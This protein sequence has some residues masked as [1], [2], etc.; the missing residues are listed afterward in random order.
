MQKHMQ[1]QMLKLIS[2]IRNETG[3][4]LAEI[5]GPKEGEARD[6]MIRALLQ[7]ANHAEQV[8]T[9]RQLAA[10]PSPSPDDEIGDLHGI[11]DPE[12]PGCGSPT[13]PAGECLP[14][15]LA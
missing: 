12:D 15:H 7:Q 2:A 13:Y 6:K 14:N 11:L 5:A 1:N 9:D 3:E 10:E 4:F 8:L